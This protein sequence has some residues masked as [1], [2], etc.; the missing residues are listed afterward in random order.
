MVE[1]G[2]R[3]PTKAIGE[4]A[5]HFEFTAETPGFSILAIAIT[6][7]VRVMETGVEDYVFDNATGGPIKGVRI[8]ALPEVITLVRTEATTDD[9]GHYSLSLTPGSYVLVVLAIIA[10][11]APGHTKGG[12]AQKRFG[13]EQ[14]ACSSMRARLQGYR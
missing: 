14:G 7:P 13:E 3:L 4:D 10:Y 11:R 1:N 12:E 9:M 6:V 8:I 5:T 2:F